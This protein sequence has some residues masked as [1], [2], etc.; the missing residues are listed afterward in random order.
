MD[1]TYREIT[2]QQ[3]EHNGINVQVVKDTVE[4]NELANKKRVPL[5]SVSQKS[6]VMQL[7]FSK[8]KEFK[9]TI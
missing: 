8:S 4:N 2:C 1:K 7:V 9:F 5:I 3:T 6:P